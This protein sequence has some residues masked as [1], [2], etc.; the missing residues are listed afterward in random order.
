MYT[1]CTYKPTTV[2]IIFD[3]SNTV[4]FPPKTLNK[5]RIS[6]LTIPIQHHTG[7]SNNAIDKKN[8]YNSYRLE[9][10]KINCLNF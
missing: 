4:F 2:N 8:K 3:G 9:S 1:K 5:E 7:D 6:F 10:E